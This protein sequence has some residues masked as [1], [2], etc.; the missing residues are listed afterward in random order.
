[1]VWLTV[2]AAIHGTMVGGLVGY[3]REKPFLAGAAAVFT[4]IL[5]RTLLSIKVLLEEIKERL[6]ER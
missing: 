6:P 1:M 3:E 5:L 2:I 4:F